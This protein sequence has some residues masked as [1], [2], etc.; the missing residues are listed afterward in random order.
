ML[1]GQDALRLLER[2]GIP[3]ASGI[4][5][6]SLAALRSA[7][8]RMKAPFVLKL[9]GRSFLHKS[10]WGGIVT[11]IGN[12]SELKAAREKITE[13]VRARDPGVAINAFHLQEQIAGT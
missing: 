4:E 3:A 10:E 9:A 6:A 2:Y 13:N 7:A 11:G 12:L 8:K 1:L 5:A